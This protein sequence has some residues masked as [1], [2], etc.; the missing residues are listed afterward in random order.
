[1]VGENVSIFNYLIVA[2]GLRPVF[3]KEIMDMYVKSKID[4]NLVNDHD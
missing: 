1:M 2:K 3:I 4:I